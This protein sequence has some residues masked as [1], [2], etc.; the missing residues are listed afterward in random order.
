MSSSNQTRFA[1]SVDAIRPLVYRIVWPNGKEELLTGTQ[2]LEKGLA[3]LNAEC[4]IFE[5]EHVS[6]SDRQE[7]QSLD[8]VFY[9]A[10]DLALHSDRDDDNLHLVRLKNALD[11]YDK[12]LLRNQANAL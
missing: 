10:Y 2:M 8:N 3:Y 9:A 4:T 11:S 1:D 12:T 7:R 5:Y 6:A